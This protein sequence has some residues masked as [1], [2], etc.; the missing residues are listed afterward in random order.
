M[1]GVRRTFA[2]NVILERAGLLSRGPDGRIDLD[3][4]QIVMPSWGR[5]LVLNGRDRKAGIVAEADRNQIVERARVALAEYRDPDTGKAIVSRFFRPDERREPGIG[6]MWGGDLYLDLIPGYEAVD[7]LGTEAVLT[8][9]SRIGEGD[10]GFWP[11]RV[12]MRAIFA[13]GGPGIKSTTQLGEM[14]QIDVAPTISA[15]LGTPAP[16]QSMGRVLTE[17]LKAPF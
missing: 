12:G 2:P 15:I 17:I 8:H 11:G 5:F 1:E 7:R 4:T 13:I 14:R 16:S 3:R 9:L 10:H 6:G